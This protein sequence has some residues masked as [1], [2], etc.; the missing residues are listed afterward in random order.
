MK[1][2]LFRFIKN[3]ALDQVKKYGT[4]LSA[5]KIINLINERFSEE[6]KNIL[7]KLSIL[8]P[9]DNEYILYDIIINKEYFKY[10]IID[11]VKKL[12]LIQKI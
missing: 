2:D 7:S 12:Y 10:D 11:N 4:A 1:D 8:N 5:D 3:K 9:D 6:I